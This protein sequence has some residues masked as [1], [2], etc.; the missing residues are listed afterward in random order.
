MKIWRQ[1]D[2]E[3][4]KNILEALNHTII[5]GKEID[6]NPLYREAQKQFAIDAL[7]YQ[8]DNSSY[9]FGIEKDDTHFTYKIIRDKDGNLKQVI[10]RLSDFYP[11]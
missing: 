3:N 5:K 10:F 7:Q 6:I 4:K 9:Y 8:T 2:W 1:Q 11:I